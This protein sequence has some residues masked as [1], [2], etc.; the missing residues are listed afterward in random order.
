MPSSKHHH[1]CLSCTVWSFSTCILF[2]TIVLFLFF[3]NARTLLEHASHT[4]H[5][6]FPCKI[7]ENHWSTLHI[8]ITGIWNQIE[9]IICTVCSAACLYLLDLWF[10]SIFV[11]HIFYTYNVSEYHLIFVDDPFA[12]SGI[13]GSKRKESLLLE[14]LRL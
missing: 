14:N 1:V 10:D 6:T 4:F 11:C 13:T 12:L 9:S 5:H 3:L 7:L 2:S 8:I